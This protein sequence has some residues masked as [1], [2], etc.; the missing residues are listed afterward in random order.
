MTNR[1]FRLLALTPVL[2]LAL[3]GCGDEKEKDL[4]SKISDE[5]EKQ[6]GQKPK[7]VDCPKDVEDAKQG[8]T[9]DCTIEA[10][11]GQKQ[12]VNVRFVDDDLNFI[13]TP[14]Q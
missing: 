7:S 12:K 14:A 8:S 5:Y 10:E 2:A 4:E 3:A 11:G 13:V 1:R 9:Y 6:A